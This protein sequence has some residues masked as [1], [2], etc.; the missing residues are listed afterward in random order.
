MFRK[1]VHPSLNWGTLFPGRRRCWRNWQTLSPVTSADDSGGARLMAKIIFRK[2]PQ[3]LKGEIIALTDWRV[4]LLS[5]ILGL[6]DEANKRLEIKGSTSTTPTST[7]G[8]STSKKS[9][10][11]TAVTSSFHVVANNSTSTGYSRTWPPI[12]SVTFSCREKTVSVN[13]LLDTG[14]GRSYL[15]A[16]VLWGLCSIETIGVNFQ[17]KQSTFLG[18]CHRGFTEV[19]LGIDLGLGKTVTSPVLVAD[20]M[21]L[22]VRLPN[23]ESLLRGFRGANCSLAGRFKTGSDLIPI[24]G[25][26][27]LNLIQHLNSL[28]LIPCFKGWTLSVPSGQVPF[29][30]VDSFFPED[31]PLY[32]ATHLSFK[33]V[34]KRTPQVDAF[35]LCFVLETQSIYLDPVA[36]CFPDSAV[37]RGLEQMLTLESLGLPN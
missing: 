35:H 22:S 24:K 16:D 11:S 2:F 27:G 4:P 18:E 8:Q 26:I 14:S 21:D 37:Q 3:E 10:R 19:V 29:G 7:I 9:V 5:S 15:S 34:M 1:G 32:E 28:K 30:A 20:V 12:L 23:L 31:M 17:L 33:S 13:C 36:E 6:T 25:I